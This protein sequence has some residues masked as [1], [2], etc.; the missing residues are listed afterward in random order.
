MCHISLFKNIF[1]RKTLVLS[2]FSF[3]L[4]DQRCFFCY[5]WFVK[6]KFLWQPAPTHPFRTVKESQ[7]QFPLIVKGILS[8]FKSPSNVLEPLRPNTET[9]TKTKNS[10]NIITAGEK[11]KETKKQVLSKKSKGHAPENG[12]G[13]SVRQVRTNAKLHL[14]KTQDSNGLPRFLTR[15]YVT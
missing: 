9:K 14:H 11:Q 1:L 12:E 13:R 5:N 3:I 10:W 7:S 2:G 15:S 8:L 4:I 6:L